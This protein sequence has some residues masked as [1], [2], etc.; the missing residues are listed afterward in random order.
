MNQTNHSLDFP[1][2]HQGMQ[3][4]LR[5]MNRIINCI[6]DELMLIDR[7]ARIVF[8]NKATVR[9]LGY[10][11]EAI[12]KRHVVDFFLRRM[13]VREW[14]KKYFLELKRRDQPLSFNLERRV[15][16]GKIQTIDVTAV[17]MTYGDQGYILSI[18]RDVTRQIAT[19][20]SLKE[21]EDLYRLLS[22]GAGDG[23]LSVD[24]RGKITYANPALEQLSG[25]CFADARSNNFL[26]YVDRQSLAK[27]LSCF[28]KAR[29]GIKNIREEIDILDRDGRKISVEINAAPL[30]K[31][32][33][34]VSIHAIVRDV[35]RR[36]QLEQLIVE[37]EKM[38]A[39]QFFVSGT[40][41][42]LKNP[43]LA[44][45]QRLQGIVQNYQKRDFEYISFRDFSDM[46]RTLEQISNQLRYCYLTTERL[47]DMSRKRGN[48]QKLRCHP[49]MVIR[50]IIQ[51]K[52]NDLKSNGIH[53]HLHLDERIPLLAMGEIEFKQV[54]THIVSNAIQA[55]PGGG[56]L[57]IRSVYLPS[58]RRILIIIQDTGV[59]IS[60]E[61]LPH[62][63][64]PF[65]TTRYGGVEKSSGLGLSI[66]HAL[67]TASRGNILVQ[68]SLRRGTIVKISLPVARKH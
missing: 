15:K 16:G 14:E 51:L 32:G 65:F 35:R 34:I 63:Y 47:V 9:A 54:I 1:R 5:L 19:Q 10:T 58:E 6:G 67:V 57:K 40:A 4:E 41:D 33:K 49:N 37:S 55:M 66:A 31:D 59:G 17:Y 53:C 64:E 2:S 56:G 29:N 42:E 36:K 25:I 52:D 28:H 48:I 26:K 3:E 7:N 12:L 45:W 62:I 39:I 43:L 60:K 38:K 20:R 22:E 50:E 18:A 8:V 23:I 30:Y 21:S 11:R 44:V 46:M 27:A 13:S 61:N 68:S 24:L